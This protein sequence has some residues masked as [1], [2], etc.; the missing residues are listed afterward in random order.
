MIGLQ[1]RREGRRG[2]G[3]MGERSGETRAERRERRTVQVSPPSHDREQAQGQ[4]TR[5]RTSAN[6]PPL[7]FTSRDHVTSR[8]I[9]L[10]QCREGRRGGSGVERQDQSERESEERRTVQVS[11]PTTVN[12]LEVSPHERERV[13]ASPLLHFASRGHVTDQLIGSQR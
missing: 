2:D 5:A 6:K 9:G 8:M 10:R 11:P 1:Q 3:E 13:R 12:E 4:P 7:H